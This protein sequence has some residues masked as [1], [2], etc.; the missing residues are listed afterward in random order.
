[1]VL[2]R[3][4]E[5]ETEKVADL[6]YSSAARPQSIPSAVAR[7]WLLVCAAD[8]EALRRADASDAD[9]VVVDLEDGV[10]D[11]DKDFARQQVHRRLHTGC[12][13]WLRINDATTRHWSIDLDLLA[14]TPTPAGVMLAKAESAEQVEAT[15]ARLGNQVPIVPLIESA[16]GLENVRAI[17]AASLVRLAFGSGDFRRDTGAGADPVALAYA[18]S[19][20][21]VASR[22]ERISAPIDGPSLTDDLEELRADIKVGTSAGMAGKLCLTAA[23]AEPINTALSPSTDDMAWARTLI[24]RLGEDGARIR[25]GSERPQLDRA[26]KIKARAEFFGPWGAR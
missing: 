12:P 8:P 20:L 19:R 24:D 4:S 18:R 9:V 10:A 6:T 15:A 1:M 26:L 13:T 11:V 21:V 17:A 23:H 16:V 25:S 3:G 14:D 5:Q 22:A 7:S 2:I